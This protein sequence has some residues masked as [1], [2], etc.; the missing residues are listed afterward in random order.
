MTKQGQWAQLTTSQKC[1]YIFDYYKFWI[2]GIVGVVVI[3]GDLFKQTLGIHQDTV[4]AI[5]M[6]NADVTVE[7]E[8]LLFDDYLET[9]YDTAFETLDINANM[10]FR[11]DHYGDRKS[12][13]RESVY[14][15]GKISVVADAH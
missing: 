10:T 5:M 3:L 11:K 4:L 8:K 7:S 15:L 12:V 1:Q 13:V 14:D 2:V 9:Y 6:I